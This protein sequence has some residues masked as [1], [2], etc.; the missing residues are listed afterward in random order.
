MRSPSLGSAR[1]E[2][3][4]LEPANHKG[5]IRKTIRFDRFWSALV[6][7]LALAAT[8]A[9][10]QGRVPPSN[11]A[12][13]VNTDF[14]AAQKTMEAGGWEIVHSSLA[15]KTQYLWN[16]DSQ[17]CVSLKIKAKTVGAFTTIENG[18]CTSRVA[19]ARK[20]F[21]NYAD[22][23]SDAHS[24]SLDFEREKLSGRGYK[25]TYW[26][27]GDATTRSLE[28]WLSADGKK[29]V[30]LVFETKDATFVQTSSNVA[31]QCVNPAPK[32]SK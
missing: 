2:S 29:C 19:A 25:A 21:E 10:A 1:S 17:T 28:Y 24:A 13:L 3:L 4:H 11:L 6:V 9:W 22:D 30:G 31:K 12:D 18:E 32:K 26:V 7:A 27:K 15:A 20:V 14:K 23:Q 16:Q 8:S 5:V